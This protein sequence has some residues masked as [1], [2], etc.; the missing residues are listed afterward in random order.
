MYYTNSEIR[1]VFHEKSIGRKLE[2]WNASIQE[3]DMSE[4]TMKGIKVWTGTKPSKQKKG[5]GQRGRTQQRKQIYINIIDEK[6]MTWPL[7]LG[8]TIK[9]Q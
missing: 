4:G 2:P 8:R 9:S 3:T 6:V 7:D 1:E 5:G